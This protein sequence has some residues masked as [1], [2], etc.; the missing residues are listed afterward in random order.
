MIGASK[1]ERCLAAVQQVG[2]LEKLA[3]YSP[4][5]VSTILV[6]FDIDDSDIDIV[7]CYADADE[8]K[9]TFETVFSAQQ[10]LFCEKRNSYV[11]GRFV[12]SG[13]Q[14]EIY[15]SSE[16]IEEQNAVRHFNVMRRL[17]A[18][19]GDKLRQQIKHLKQ[20]GLKTEPAIAALFNFSG[21]PYRAVLAIEQ[22][23]DE[24]L[25]RNLDTGLRMRS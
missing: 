24:D 14:F 1:K 22:W 16:P 4:A 18:I 3:G 21:D 12:S 25:A 8:F 5:V 10:R 9:T 13:F 6:G 19:G 2:V 7:C 20:Q 23:T 17:S 11:I 15:A